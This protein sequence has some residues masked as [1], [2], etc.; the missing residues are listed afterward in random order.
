MVKL[1]KRALAAVF[2]ALV[3][4]IMFATI[5]LGPDNANAVQYVKICSL[6]GAGYYYIPGT[7]I[8]LN[9]ETNDARQAS[10]LQY[11]VADLPAC[12]SPNVF[13]DD[14]TDNNCTAGGTPL[15]D[16]TAFCE[17]ACV[18]GAWQFTGNNTIGS[19][20]WRI[21]N[22]PRTWTQTS[23]GACPGGQL[24]KFGDIDN[25][26]LFQNSFRRYQTTTQYPLN[27]KPGQ[28]IA[29]VLYKGGFTN[30]AGRG[31]FCLYYYDPASA[32][33]AP[34][35]GIVFPPLGCLDTSSQAGLPAISVFSPDVPAP[36]STIGAPALIGANGDDWKAM[37]AQDIQGA[38]SIWLCI[39]K[40]H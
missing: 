15:G 35:Y 8:C 34:N 22:N 7:D 5:M 14:A 23:A 33:I 40:A 25:S 21:P 20:D 18:G 17:V 19:W 13:V 4:A 32:S 38:L 27:L 36:P 24:V 26:G 31:N 9:T 3:A 29:S 2:P 28:Y 37:S 12:P 11:D 30:V 39:Q 1:R 10:V 16:G 6:Y